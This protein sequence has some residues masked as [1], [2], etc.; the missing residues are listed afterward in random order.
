MGTKTQTVGNR[1][2]LG[3]VCVVV[4]P[5]AGVMSAGTVP[6]PAGNGPGAGQV[7]VGV[8][9][10]ASVTWI[11]ALIARTRRAEA[12]LWTTASLAVTGA[13]VLLLVWFVETYIPT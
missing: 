5:V 10:P 12:C 4:A 8:G 1:V 2:L 3:F 11:A 13:L 9:V 6:N 7:I